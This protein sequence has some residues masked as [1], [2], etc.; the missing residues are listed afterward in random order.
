MI[1]TVADLLH[2]LIERERSVLG[3][4]SIP[5]G[6]TIGAMDEGLTRAALDRVIPLR[7]DATLSVAKGFARGAD[8]ALSRQL[9]CMLVAGEGERIP[10]SGDHI[11]PVEQVIA[12]VE[13][14]KTIEGVIKHRAYGFHSAAAL[15]AMV[16]L[17]CSDIVI[18]L[19]I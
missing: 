2:S 4:V 11:Y 6:P 8:G 17:C 5:H 12:V 9:D 7:D 13:V 1:K 19:P 18:T 15:I 14:K 16:F 10:Y 3:K